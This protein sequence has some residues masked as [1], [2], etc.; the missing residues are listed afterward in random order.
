MQVLDVPPNIEA[1][2]QTNTFLFIVTFWVIVFKGSYNRYTK[3]KSNP[4]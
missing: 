4:L 1:A 2:Y 3:T